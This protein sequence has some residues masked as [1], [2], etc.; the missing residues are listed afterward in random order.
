MGKNKNKMEQAQEV[1]ARVDI[2]CRKRC[3]SEKKE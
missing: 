2:K 1:D 3:S